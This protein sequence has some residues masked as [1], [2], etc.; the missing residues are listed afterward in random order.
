MTLHVL[1]IANKLNL[2][3]IFIRE[4]LVL[5]IVEREREREEKEVVFL[6]AF[7]ATTKFRASSNFD[8]KAFFPQMGTR[9][10][11]KL[12]G[13]FNVKAFFFLFI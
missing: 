3:R 4:T 10:L 11:E 13:Y 2:V 1:A 12:D 9:A 7:E 8:E 5:L 6:T